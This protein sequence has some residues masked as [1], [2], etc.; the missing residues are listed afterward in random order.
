MNAARNLP[1]TFSAFDN[2][3]AAGGEVAALR[4]TGPALREAIS[5]AL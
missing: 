5:P 3:G 4:E 2:G 1:L